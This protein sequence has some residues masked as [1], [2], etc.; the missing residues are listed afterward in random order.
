MK[1]ALA[2]NEQSLRHDIMPHYHLSVDSKV[3]RECCYG[4]FLFYDHGN[5]LWSPRAGPGKE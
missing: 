5:Q 1:F 2:V 3:K 4:V